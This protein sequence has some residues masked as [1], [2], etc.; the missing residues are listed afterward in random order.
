MSSYEPSAVDVIL[1]DLLGPVLGRPFYARIVSRL[2]L[3][4]TEEVLEFGSGPGILSKMMADRLSNGRLT[5]VDVSSRWL[6]VARR[7]LRG[8]SNVRF[9]EGDVYSLD[10]P[11]R[12]FDMVVLN[13]VL[14]DIPEAERDDVVETLAKVVRPGGRLF[15]QEPIG[16]RH[17]MP[18]SEAR[19]L[20]EGAGLKELSFQEERRRFRGLYV[21]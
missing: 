14:H 20:L 18:A 12:S 16:Q 5:L 15:I 7:R 9:L 1:T 2:G 13:Y 10:L 8:R 6:R 4:G 19:G 17:G 11:S 21:R 3:R